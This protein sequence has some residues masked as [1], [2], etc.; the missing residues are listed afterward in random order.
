MLIDRVVSL[1]IAPLGRIAGL[2]RICTLG[3]EVW[4]SG[5]VIG[6]AASDSDPHGNTDKN[7]RASVAL[8]SCGP[9]SVRG[10]ATRST[11]SAREAGY[12]QRKRVA[13]RLYNYTDKDSSM[14]SASSPS[15]R[16]AYVDPNYPVEHSKNCGAGYR[17][18]KCHSTCL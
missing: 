7:W 14:A 1:H 11:Q 13:G 16:D 3:L 4:A 6:D 8:S 17:Q 18:Q 5:L 2:A 15:D 9:L 12:A 10:A